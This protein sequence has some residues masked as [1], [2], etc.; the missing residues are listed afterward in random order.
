MGKKKEIRKN[1]E[2]NTKQF[3]LLSLLKKEQCLIFFGEGGLGG[4]HIIDR[5]YTYIQLS[6]EVVISLYLIK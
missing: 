2:E 3:P 6:T 4:L 1:G 5:H